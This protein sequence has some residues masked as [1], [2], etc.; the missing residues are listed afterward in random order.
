MIHFKGEQSVSARLV[1]SCSGSLANVTC[2]PG[3]GANESGS[4]NALEVR[5]HHLIYR[6]NF[7][8][9]QVAPVRESGALAARLRSFTYALI[10]VGSATAKVGDAS[11]CAG[12]ALPSRHRQKSLTLPRSP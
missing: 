11:G 4:D 1:R 10:R 6:V 3:V 2:I 12:S 8:C 5:N 7:Q 9:M